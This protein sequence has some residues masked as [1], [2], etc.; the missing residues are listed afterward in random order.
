MFRS[1]DTAP[2]AEA[3]LRQNLADAGPAGRLAIALALSDD[4]RRLALVGASLRVLRRG[5]GDAAEE[6]RR[7]YLG[8]EVA[9]R[10]DQWR[11]NRCG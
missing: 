9:A 6:V 7:L 3:Q 2:S 1:P 5:S 8:A 11:R 10:I 4:V